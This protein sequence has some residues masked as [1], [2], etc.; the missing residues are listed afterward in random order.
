VASWQDAYRVMLEAARGT[1]GRAGLALLGLADAGWNPPAPASPLGIRQVP[2]VPKAAPGFDPMVQQLRDMSGFAEMSRQWEAL[3]GKI[4]TALGPTNPRWSTFTGELKPELIL[5]AIDKCN[6]GYPFLLCDMYRRAVEHD[7]HLQG[8]IPF[9][10][11]PIITAGDRID[12][13]ESQAEDEVAISHANWLRAV[14]EQ[15]HNFDH[16]RYALLWAEGQSYACVETIYGIR[17]I[18][19]YTAAGKRISRE[20][21]VPVDFE[22]VDGRSFQ[23]DITTDEPL[24]WLQGDYATLPPAKFIFHTAHGFTS[25]RERRGFMRSCLFLHAIKQWCVRDLATYL[26]IYGIPQMI[27]EYAP[28]FEVQYPE[29]KRIAARIAEI[30]GQGGIPDVP[31]GQVAVRQV[32]AP[33]EGALVHSE[34][35]SWLNTE[36]TIAVTASGPA[37]MQDGGSSY[38]LGNVHAAGALPTTQMRGDN[39]CHSIRTQLWYPTDQLNRYRLAEDLGTSPDDILATLPDYTTQLEREP[40][41]AKRQQV[42]SQ[43]MEDGC[44]VDEVQYRRTMQLNKPRKGARILKGKGTPIPSSGAVVS[45]VDAS[46][47]AVAPVPGKDGPQT[48]EVRELPAAQKDAA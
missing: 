21:C 15:I 33:V 19:W 16:M 34:A 27:M 42:F 20:Y 6:A 10:F 13:R 14:R 35:A 37:T 48:P 46:Q 28:Q 31:A 39:L 30:F 41:M 24:L 5:G 4:T 7:T 2:Q 18:I 25:I 17:R 45:A 12:P 32:G 40:D 38:G 23:F 11:A 8:V 1:A 43:A 29:A 3:F 22:I 26:H 9:A 47:G 36:M 44:E